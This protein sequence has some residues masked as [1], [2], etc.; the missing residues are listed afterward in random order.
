MI[1]WVYILA[2]DDNKYFTVGQ[3]RNLVR[4]FEMYDYEDIPTCPRRLVALY[5]IELRECDGAD[6]GAQHPLCLELEEKITLQMMKRLGAGWH[7]VCS[8]LGIFDERSSPPEN[9]NPFPFPSCA[10]AECPQ[11]NAGCLRRNLLLLPK[12]KSRL[13]LRTTIS[14]IYKIRSVRELRVFCPYRFLS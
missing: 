9:S 5:R 2:T 1:V 8:E 6:L 7:R 12:K 10:T 13:A 14:R 4:C 11:K 3:A